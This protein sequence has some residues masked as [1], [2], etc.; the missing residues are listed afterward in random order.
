MDVDVCIHDLEQAAK[1]AGFARFVY[2]TV[3]R[4]RLLG[5]TRPASG[6]LKNNPA[7]SISL[8]GSTA[9]SQPGRW[10]YWNCFGRMHSPV[11]IIG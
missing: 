8:P 11:T 5:L 10:H 4:A 2:G 1:A 6:R 9:M 3:D 7:R